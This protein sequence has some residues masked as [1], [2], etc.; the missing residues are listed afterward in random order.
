[1]LLVCRF[2]EEI[3]ERVIKNLI[4]G[5]FCELFKVG[6]RISSTHV[7]VISN[8]RFN[9][10]KNGLWC[11]WS[12][13]TLLLSIIVLRDVLLLL[14]CGCCERMLLSIN[15]F[16]RLVNWGRC[17]N[18]RRGHWIR[19]STQGGSFCGSVT[20]LLHY[21][22]SKCIMIYIIVCAVSIHSIVFRIVYLLYIVLCM[23]Y[24]ILVPD[25][26]LYRKY[27]KFQRGR[28]CCH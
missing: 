12:L 17:R 10:W 2:P 24:H 16:E 4:L 11:L 19:L 14:C 22:V 3:E 28:S 25:I 26:D 20:Y 13:K 7:D 18:R 8:F 9:H 21:C 23:L 5:A 15:C 6:F 27:V 1:M